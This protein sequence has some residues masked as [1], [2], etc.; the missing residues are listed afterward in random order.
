MAGITNGIINRTLRIADLVLTETLHQPLLRLR[1]HDHEHANINIVVD[2][3]LDETVERS[4]FACSGFSSLLKPE[5]AR[6]SNRYGSKQTHCLIIEFMPRF[7]ECDEHRQALAE[8]KHA[9]SAGSRSLARQIWSEF[10]AQDPATSL[11]VEGLVIQLLGMQFRSRKSS[12]T[13]PIWLQRCRDLLE[14]DSQPPRS[15]SQLSRQL[16]VDRSH[17]TE[18]FAAHFGMSPG[19]Y[20]RRRRIERAREL[21]RTTDKPLC[22]VA[23]ELGFYDQSHLGRVFTAQTGCTPAEFRRICRRQ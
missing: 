23:V 1:S 16:G 22:E 11:V 3:Y 9:S 19:A 8:V 6:H 7:G 20:L 5:S 4:T 17:L 12:N 18:R 21:L 2:G 10:S 13:I 14:D 15:I